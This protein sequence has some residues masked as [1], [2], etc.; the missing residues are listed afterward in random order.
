MR[1][2]S[3]PG[4]ILKRSGGSSATVSPSMPACTGALER[5]SNSGAD[6]SLHGRRRNRWRRPP[7]EPPPAIA[8]P[9]QPVVDPRARARAD[10]GAQPVAVVRD[11]DHGGAPMHGAVPARPLEIE[12]VPVRADDVGNRVEE[13]AQ[14]GAAVA[15]A[16][17]GLGVDAERR[18]VDEDAPVHLGEVDDVLAG[19]RAERVE[20]PEVVLAVDAEVERE[21]VARARRD[22][23]VRQVVLCRD[24][25]DDGLRPVAARH[26]EAVGAAAERRDDERLE[27]VAGAQHDHLQPALA[28]RADEPRAL[29]PPVPRA[30]VDEEDG[31]QRGLDDRQRDAHAEGAP[32]EDHRDRAADDGEPGLGHQSAMQ[33]RRQPGE[34]QGSREH[35]GGGAAVPAPPHAPPGGRRREQEQERRRAADRPVAREHDR[36]PRQGQPAHDE[37]SAGGHAAPAH[38][39]LRR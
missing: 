26:R 32:R 2:R 18:V 5:T 24:P 30:R 37:R 7:P 3:T 23:G 17:D 36:D 22:A 21:V 12:G 28:C 39:M 9:E 31:M 27:V 11:E 29:R 34:Q 25:R 20:R 15:L 19:A 8:M 13:R 16:L 38:G 1:A 14:L 4:R 10:D 6:H 33:E 35:E